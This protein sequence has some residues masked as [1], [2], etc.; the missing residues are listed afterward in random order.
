[1]TTKLD[2]NSTSSLWY[3]QS[4]EEWK[5]LNKK[6]NDHLKST[7]RN[8]LMCMCS[9]NDDWVLP[10]RSW[11]WIDQWSQGFSGKKQ[12]DWFYQGWLQ[13]NPLSNE[14]W[15]K[16]QTRSSLF[17]SEKKPPKRKYPLTEDFFL[18]PY[19]VQDLKSTLKKIR[20]KVTIFR[21]EGEIVEVHKG[22]YLSSIE[23]PEGNHIELVEYL[24]LEEYRSDL[25]LA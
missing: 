6:L 16:N 3:I 2:Q 12:T 22:V 5:P 23:D 9:W 7:F 15:W 20:S 17:N 21:T 1:M 13:D 14:S 24:N 18:W 25:K 4:L 11:V 8:W 19:I 10:W